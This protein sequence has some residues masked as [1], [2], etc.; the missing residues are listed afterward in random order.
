M[1]ATGLDRAIQEWW[2]ATAALSAIIPPERVATEIM[3]SNEDD[4]EA[5]NDADNDDFFD[6]CVVLRITTEPHWRT[7]TGRGYQSTVR[8]MTMAIDYDTAH[9]V[10]QQV[11]ASWTDQTFQGSGSLISWCRPTGEIDATQDEQTQVW[12]FTVPLQMNHSG[13]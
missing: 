13:V 11:L 10:A 5:T 4:A 12:M 6:P 3:Q 9:D 8:L 7:N 2:A 1:A